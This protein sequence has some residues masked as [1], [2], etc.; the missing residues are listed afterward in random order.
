[1]IAAAVKSDPVTYNEAFLGKLNEEYVQWILN[2]EKWGGAIEL[3]IL[4]DHYARE[5]AAYDIQTMR[6]DLYGQ[7]KGLTERVMLL[8]DGLHYDVLA[9][10]PFADAPEE[11]D[12][13]IFNV[14]K[15]G[16]IGSTAAL[17]ANFVQEAHRARKYTD[18]GKF[19][20]RCS[21]CQKGVVGEKVAKSSSYSRLVVLFFLYLLCSIQAD[22]LSITDISPLKNLLCRRQ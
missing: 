17:A 6:C 9:V 15:S 16:S 20:L 10:A 11:V 7:G 12:Q 19:T 1:V 13:T 21:V 5:I 2:P 14:D 18:T 3:S 8:Y 4:C 22:Y